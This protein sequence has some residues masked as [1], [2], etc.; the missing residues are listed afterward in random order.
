MNESLLLL[1]PVFNEWEL[2]A[3]LLQRID[4]ALAAA[5]IPAD[6]VLLD[7]ASTLEAEGRLEVP[8]LSA[9]R[10]F[11]ILRLARNLGH[12]RAISI[13][14]AWASDERGLITTAFWKWRPASRQARSK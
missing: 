2:L 8:K 11:E 5:Q 12:Q 4:A 13:G 6:V 1:I 14:L 10:S 7:D 9:V 3:A